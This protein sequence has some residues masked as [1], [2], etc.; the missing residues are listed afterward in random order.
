MEC[1]VAFSHVFTTASVEDCIVYYVAG[2]LCRKL[3][4][5]TARSQ[6]KLGLVSQ[7][8]SSEKPE[9]AFVNCRTRGNQLHPTTNVFSLV[10]ATDTCFQKHSASQFS[11]ELTLDEVVDNFHFSFPCAT[12]KIDITA[13]ILLTIS[14]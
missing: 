12:H 1:E 2:Y 9:S 14:Q 4:R 10:C 8:T 5:Y 7:T 3:L 13:Q 11:H 6:C